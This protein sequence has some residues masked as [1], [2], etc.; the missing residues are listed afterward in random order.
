[1]STIRLELSL[2]R[3]RTI[4]G[5]V[6]HVVV[7]TVLVETIL[8]GGVG[9]IRNDH[10][11]CHNWGLPEGSVGLTWF[12][13]ERDLPTCRPCLRNIERAGVKPTIKGVRK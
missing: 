13:A 3:V 5:R 9:W 2:P 8:T 12:P 6:G 11:A 4:K 1:M 10:V 7:D